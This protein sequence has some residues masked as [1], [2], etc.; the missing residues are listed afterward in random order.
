MSSESDELRAERVQN[1]QKLIEEHSRSGLSVPA[2]CRNRRVSAT[3][4]YQWRKKLQQVSG[5]TVPVL[6]PVKLLSDDHRPKTAAISSCVQVLTPSGISLA[7][8]AI[9][10]EEELVKVL[11][12]IDT[13]EANRPC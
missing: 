13:F 5:P 8:S 4:F 2:F 3:S 1:W 6:V 11:R 12:A 9:A 10:S 7:V